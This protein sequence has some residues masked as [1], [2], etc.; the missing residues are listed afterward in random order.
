MDGQR[1]NDVLSKAPAPVPVTLT[2]ID[3][4]QLGCT[5]WYPSIPYHNDQYVASVEIWL[6]VLTDAEV[7][8]EYQK[9]TTRMVP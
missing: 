2:N 7:L 8:E 1:R 5:K 4:I 9:S 3:T 6:R